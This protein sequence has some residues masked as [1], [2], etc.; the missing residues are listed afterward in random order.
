MD[1]L[2]SRDAQDLSDRDFRPSQGAGNQQIP[3]PERLRNQ[4]I[5]QVQ[6]LKIVKFAEAVSRKG[7]DCVYTLRNQKQDAKRY[8]KVASISREL[9]SPRNKTTVEILMELFQSRQPQSMKRLSRMMRCGQYLVSIQ[10][11]FHSV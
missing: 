11:L 6:I 9:V 3:P 10:R 1:D 4:K 8:W 5:Y 7:E 2:T